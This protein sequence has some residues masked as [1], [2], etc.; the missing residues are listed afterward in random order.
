MTGKNMVL[1][2]TIQN[3]AEQKFRRLDKFLPHIERIEVELTRQPTRHV[4]DHYVCQA[5]VIVAGNL[6][7]RGEERAADARVAVDALADLLE[8]L[9]QRQH[10]K[11][12]SLRRITAPG[13]LPPAPDEAF[14]EPSTLEIVLGDFGI[15]PATITHLQE[16]GIRTIEQL[17]SVVDDGHLTA[18]L[19]PGWERQ[20]HDLVQVVEKLRM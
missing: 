9:L 19:G 14:T 20:A 18:W 12:E 11:F 1:D 15:D 7:L 8:Q 4:Q 13:R 5:N 10:G 2:D 16:R 6:M 3:Y 17:R